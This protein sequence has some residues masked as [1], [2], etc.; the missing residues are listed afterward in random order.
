[1]PATIFTEETDFGVRIYMVRD[2]ENETRYVGIT[3][4]ILPNINAFSGARKTGYSVNWFV[5]IDD[6]H[7]WKYTFVLDRAE[8]LD[9]ESLRGGRTAMGSDY[10]PIPERANRYMQDRSSMQTGTFSGIPNRYFQAQDACVTEGP[11]PIQD[12]A[13]EHLAYTDRGIVA[14]RNLL[15]RAVKDVQAGREPPHVVRDPAANRFEHLVVRNDILPD[16]ADWLTYW[17]EPLA[18]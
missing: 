17:R 1:V 13:Q 2:L 5:P 6:T 14:S 16:S 10:R 15:L 18:R 12:R 7:Y 11:G 8:P 3:D 4:Y 9:K